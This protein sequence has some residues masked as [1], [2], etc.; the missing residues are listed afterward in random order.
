MR[1]LE[2]PWWLHLLA[3]AVL[4]IA[5]GTAPRA[6]AGTL[7]LPAGVPVDAGPLGPLKLQG[8]LS[9]L[10][11]SQSNP[12]A[13]DRSQRFD[14]DNAQFILQKNSGAWQ[15]LVQ[16][17]AYSFPTAGEPFTDTPDVLK[18]L[19]GPVPVAYVK[20]T[21]SGNVSMQAGKLPSLLGAE[22]AWP[23]GNYNIERGL[24]WNLENTITRGVQ[25]NYAQGAVSAALAWTDGFY[26]NRFDNFTGQFTYNIDPTNSLSVAAYATLRHTSY[27]STATPQALNNARI[28]N[29]IFTH[30]SGNW[31]F[32]PYLQY[33]FSQAS[34]QLG[35]TR[36]NS[37]TGAALLVDYAMNKTWSLGARL[38]YLTSSGADNAS[39]NN[40]LL[41]YGPGSR[42]WTV[43]VT[44]TWQAGGLFIRGEISCVRASR[45]APGLAFGSSGDQS[46][47]V[48]A[49]LEGGVMF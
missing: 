33:D 22:G 40:D 38:E 34:G 28:Y 43:T 46:G 19:Y 31:T 18:N 27:E 47:Q 20:Y 26:S 2:V 35:Y 44:P 32:T 8:M 9:G 36:G 21:F 5:L 30:T 6:K 12:V 13:G 3:G 24:L 16:G 42:A 37:A 39:P 14:V 49:L 4:A 29:V 45:F 7:A 41:G 1:K 25:F 15:F 48:R 17:G 10:A 23:W 11:V